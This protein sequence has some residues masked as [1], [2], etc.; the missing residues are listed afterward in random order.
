[1]KR[2]AIPLLAAALLFGAVGC[3]T[4]TTTTTT[5]A[6]PASVQ[7]SARDAA[8][9]LNGL[10][11]SAQAKYTASCKANPKQK[12]CTVINDGVKAQNLLIT[13]LETYCGWSAT[14]APSNLNGVCIPVSSAEAGLVAATSN[15]QTLITEL[16][17]L[18]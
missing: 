2:L 1:M 18:L 13:S 9:A 3:A 16:G 17:G 8:A 14:T 5:P 7:S 6:A 11:T 4:K 10:L 12:P 15:V